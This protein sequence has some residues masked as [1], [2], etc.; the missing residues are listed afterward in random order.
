MSFNNRKKIKHNNSKP[1][2]A[3]QHLEQSLD[4]AVKEFEMIKANPIG[5]YY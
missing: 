5:P 2:L 3:V 4:R 1:D